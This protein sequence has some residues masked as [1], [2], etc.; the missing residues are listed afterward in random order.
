MLVDSD[1]SPEAPTYLA[2]FIAW[3]VPGAFCAAIVE[4]IA[5][6]WFG[7]AAAGITGVIM[8]CCAVLLLRTCAYV[9]Q[10]RITTAVRLM[11]ASLLIA[12]ISIA[13]VQP[14][15]FPALVFVPLL[16]AA[17]ALPYT[18]EQTLSKLL[19]ACWLTT[20]WVGLVSELPQP[21][22]PAAA[23]TWFTR[24]FRQSSL[25]LAVAL[26]LLLLWQYRRR[27]TATLQQTQAAEER[28]SLAAQGA[29]DGLWD[30]D[31]CTNTVYFSPR[32]KAML[33]Y[34]PGDIGTSPHEWLERVHPDDQARV[35]AELAVHNDKLTSHFESE[36]RIRDVH[37]RYRWVLSRGL[38]VR[39]SRGTA[40]RIAGSQTDIT[41]R[42][43]VEEQLRHDA[44]HDSLTGLVNRQY[45]LD[46]LG[47]V[48]A[49]MKRQPAAGCAVLFADLDRFKMIN[50]S[51]GHGVGDELL[52]SVVRRWQ[53]CLRP[54]DTFAR[55]GGDE[56]TI[57]LDGIIAME[58]AIQ[59]AERLHAALNDPFTL[60]GSDIFTS[61]SIGI[62]LC[63]SADLRPEE[64]LR[65]ADS[66]LY[67]AKAQGKARYV[68]FDETMHADVIARLHLEM[69]LRRGIERGEFVVHYQPIVSMRNGMISS[70][71]ALVRW[72]HPER[73]LLPPSD[74]IPLAEETGLIQQLGKSVLQAACRQ[75]RTWELQFPDHP[76]FTMSVNVSGAQFSQPDFV[77]QLQACLAETQLQPNRLCIEITE[78]VMMEHAAV[79]A[80]MLRRVRSLGVPIAI[81]DFGTGY[82]SLGVLH[83]L[84]IDTLKIDRGFLRCVGTGDRR[85]LMVATIV[86]L[87][88]NLQLDVIAEGIE[89]DTQLEYMRELSCDFGQ[90]Y[91]FAQ[92]LDGEAASTLLAM[93]PHQH[94]FADTIAWDMV[95]SPTSG[96]YT[97]NVT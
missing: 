42:K 23:P 62:T 27:L 54:Q 52:I 76:H 35:L 11:C 73:G 94:P 82:S 30:W 72:Q 14:A 77:T 24:S 91:L 61:A 46:R 18:D 45:F 66:A 50:D 34:A 6:L 85:G 75:A 43:Q 13:L 8:L 78:S 93:M 15:L 68:V 60:A 40:T 16:V 48:L 3:I 80:D 63:T 69:E 96:A 19:V 44:L 51:L 95:G 38:A 86:T 12:N 81:D 53:S 26:V 92:P 49:R 87:A 21:L 56:F 47:W 9:Q 55:L 17:L 97:L 22:V 58:D 65:D 20:I 71:E 67:R 37:G 10:R 41:S 74:F 64:L 28:Y 84:P 89:T 88:H 1:P 90:G 5:C 32:W 70:F 83:Q 79:V 33:G 2:Q 39:D 59:V 57:L 36:H 25:A 4:G 31:L 7:S 29:N